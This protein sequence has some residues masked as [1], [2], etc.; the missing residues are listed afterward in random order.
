MAKPRP[1]DYFNA[2]GGA[3][4]GAMVGIVPAVIAG[5]VV[6][7][8]GGQLWGWAGSTAFWRTFFIAW[9]VIIV[10]LYLTSLYEDPPARGG[11]PPGYVPNI[12]RMGTQEY[13]L[14][15]ILNE[16]A[17]ENDRRRRQNMD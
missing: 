11:Y 12:H 8:V 1:I 10:I 9:S 7:A 14:Q 6:A 15:E 5:A 2:L 17:L 4:A 3:A 13:Y 16:Q